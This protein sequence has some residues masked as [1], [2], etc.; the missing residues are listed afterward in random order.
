[1]TARRLST[2]LLACLLL[3]SP[4]AAQQGTAQQRTEIPLWSGA[5]PGSEGKSGPE[6]VRVTD[7]GDHVVSSI[8]RPSITPY[9][10]ERNVATG[11]AVIVA[12]GG[13]HREL[14]I[15]HEGYNVAQFL[16]ERGIAAFVLKY[17]LAREEGSTY[18][19]EGNA[20][21]DIQRAIRLVRSN[22]A[23]WGLDTARIGVMGFSAGGEV[24]ARAAMSWDDGNGS[25]ADPLDRLSSRPAFQALIYPGNSSA[26]TVSKRSPPVFIAGG[27]NDRPDISRG[28]AELYLKYKEARVPAELHL[29]AAAGHGFGVRATNRS[30]SAGWPSRLVE[31]LGDMKLSRVK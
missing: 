24:A 1:M 30:A 21:A 4:L 28:M 11:A 5:A 26:L 22:A 25:A 31:W 17:R 20:L 3:A 16:R 29:Y 19:I 18:T 2:P 10:P 23:Q 9:L 15:D 27:Y 8:H 13:G 6:N 7:G 14:W 12:P